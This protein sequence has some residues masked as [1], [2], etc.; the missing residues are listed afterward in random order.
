VE[1][2]AK[3]TS[4]KGIQVDK[5]GGSFLSSMLIEVDNVDSEVEG[6]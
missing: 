1:E 4:G 5:S 3:V 6:R 2:I